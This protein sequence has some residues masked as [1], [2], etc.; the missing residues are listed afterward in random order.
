MSEAELKPSYVFGR[1]TQAEL[2]AQYNQGSLVP[3]SSIYKARK[4]AG[5]AR[6]TAE[7]RGLYD[8]AYGPSADETLDIFPAATPG[9][10]TM[11]FLHGGAW[12]NGTKEGSRWVAE[13]FVPQG[14]NVVIVNFAL[15]P[16]VSLGEQVRQAA[17]AVQWT[18]DHARDY[19]GDPERVF[20]AGHSSGGHLAGVIAVWDWQPRTLVKGVGA[21][22]GMFDLEPVRL[23]WR[24]KYLKLTDVEEAG[25]SAMRRIPSGGVPMVVGYGTGELNEFQ[26][27]S[28][29]FV[30]AWRAKGNACEELVF[31][32]LNHYEVQEQFNEA[33]GPLVKAML[34]MMGI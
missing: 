5:S 17:A 34:K 15:A 8:I 33:D 31:P 13:A 21:F 10:P 14:V 4:K 12:K 2:D 11:V 30:A 28:R 1:Y 20:V 22:S 24:N 7:F 23:S 26:R 9:G 3:D 6:V 16:D 25:L 32:G 27:Q 29:D 19:G 18:Y